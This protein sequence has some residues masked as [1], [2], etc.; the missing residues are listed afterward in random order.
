MAPT[1]SLSISMVPVSMETTLS[2]LTLISYSASLETP[3]E[4]DWSSDL[5]LCV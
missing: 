2:R 3:I 1:P 4:S 5:E